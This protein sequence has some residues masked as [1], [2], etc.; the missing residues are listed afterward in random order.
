[1]SYRTSLPLHETEDD[2][3]KKIIRKGKSRRIVRRSKG[4]IES[5]VI[6]KKVK[7]KHEK[8]T[9]KHKRIKNKRRLPDQTF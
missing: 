4:K 9:K 8:T 2:K 5:H 7:K 6:Y 3:P 1:M